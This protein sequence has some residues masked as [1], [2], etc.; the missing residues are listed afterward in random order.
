MS[1][2]EKS[3]PTIKKDKIKDGVHL[4]F[5]GTV[6]HY[7]LR[8]LIRDKVVKLLNDSPLFKKL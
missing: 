6:V 3:Q 1:V 7:K 2:F 5:Q 4:I 8:Y